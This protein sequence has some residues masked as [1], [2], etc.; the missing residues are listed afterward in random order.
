MTYLCLRYFGELSPSKLD[1]SDELTSDERKKRRIRVGSIPEIGLLLMHLKLERNRTESL[2]DSNRTT[3]RK[4]RSEVIG[5]L[6]LSMR[7]G[8]TTERS[9]DADAEI[10]VGLAEDSE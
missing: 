4:K 8:T 7:K 3:S 10:R 9:T 1:E 2:F 5:W 6:N